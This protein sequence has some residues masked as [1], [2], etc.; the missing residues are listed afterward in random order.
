MRSVRDKKEK[1][2]EKCGEIIPMGD[3]NLQILA[4]ISP[5]PVAKRPPEGLG[6]TEITVPMT[7]ENIIS[8]RFPKN[9]E[10]FKGIRPSLDPAALL[11]YFEGILGGRSRR[12]EPGKKELKIEDQPEFL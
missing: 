4:R 9:K 5:L 6:A 7:N 8:R 1:K 11:P 12:G 2:K 3:T 10:E